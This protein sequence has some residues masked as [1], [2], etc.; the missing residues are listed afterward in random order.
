MKISCFDHTQSGVISCLHLSSSV[1]L[2]SVFDNPSAKLKRTSR[3]GIS[4]ANMM[5]YTRFGNWVS[6]DVFS[7]R[8]ALIESH[9]YD[10]QLGPRVTPMMRTNIKW[11]K[12]IWKVGRKLFAVCYTKL[13]LWLNASRDYICAEVMWL[14]CWQYD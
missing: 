3:L 4:C 14:F 7:M 10:F 12:I 11:L 1:T 5:H 2:W 8:G 13:A 6:F 9:V